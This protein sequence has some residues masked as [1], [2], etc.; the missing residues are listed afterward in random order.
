LTRSVGRS[1]LSVLPIAIASRGAA[2]LIPVV[3]A[4]WFGVDQVTDAWFWALAFPTFAVVLAGSAVATTVTPALARI[5]REAPHTIPRMIGGLLVWT[6]GLALALGLCFCL[7]GPWVLEHFTDFKPET[8]TM[9]STFLWELL[10]FMVVT[11]AGAVLRAGCEV[12]RQ[13]KRVALTP[14]IRAL[15]VIGTTWLLLRPAGIH[16]LPIGLIV[17]EVVQA[18]WW[19]TW[20]VAAGIDIEPTTQLDP[21]IRQVG[22]DFAPILGGEV[23][24]ALNLVIDK[25][26]AATLTEGSVATLEFADRARVI[27]TTLLIS[28]LAMVAFATWSNHAA[29]GE[30]EKARI[31]MDQSMRWTLVLASPV[32]AG[33]FIGRYALIQLLFEHGAFE[34]SDTRMTAHVLGYY[35]PGIL[36]ALMGALALRAHIVERHLALVLTLGIASVTINFTLNSMLI[37]PLGLVGLALSTSVGATLI[38]T[39]WV[40]CL[41]PILPSG[42]FRRWLPAAGIVLASI[43]VATACE[44][45]PGPAMSVTDAQLWVTSIPCF[46]LLGCGIGTIVL[47]RTP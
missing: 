37:A 30:H 2:F 10:P 47:S 31:S 20:L 13:F 27:P 11:S 14:L 42:L 17:G 19:G 6:S 22:R 28:T 21:S 43:V 46:I 35:I 23:L 45:G 33:M 4:L 34:P 40:L 29:S 41:V 7:S 32:L 44:L 24:V 12:E 16:A 9:A 18:I 8:Q 36:P 5:K 15:V 26:F 25:G 39:I 38:A 3:V 1:T